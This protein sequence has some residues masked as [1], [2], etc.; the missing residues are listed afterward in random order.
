[1]SDDDVFCFK[2]EV[3]FDT[4]GDAKKHKLIRAYFTSRRLSRV[5][6][7]TGGSVNIDPTYKVNLEQCMAVII[8]EQDAARKFHCVGVGV[9][10][11]ERQEDITWLLQSHKDAREQF[12]PGVLYRPVVGIGDGAESISIAFELVHAT[13]GRIMY[14]FHVTEN[15]K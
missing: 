6:N 13:A 15:V 11:H 10:S 14:Y 9:I 12:N 4:G 3:I 1:M 8:G 7:Q 2:Q 5:G